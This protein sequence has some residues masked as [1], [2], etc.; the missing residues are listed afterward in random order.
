MNWKE[1]LE[2]LLRK[3]NTA[4]KVFE[5]TSY[6]Y[7]N[8]MPEIIRKFQE[9]RGLLP[10][11]TEKDVKIS[12]PEDLDALRGAVAVALARQIW[13]LDVPYRLEFLENFERHMLRYLDGL[14]AVFSK[15]ELMSAIEVLENGKDVQSI[16]VD[17]SL[18]FKGKDNIT[19]VR[20]KNT[21]D[22]QELNDWLLPLNEWA[23]ENNY[24][25]SEQ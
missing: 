8:S 21:P 16:K 13:E 19:G 20:I 22:S 7:G 25:F 11:A 4:I 1:T 14:T 6:L 10:N 18:I 24:F 17:K 2:R 15:E 12:T 3:S 9:R 5:K 23:D